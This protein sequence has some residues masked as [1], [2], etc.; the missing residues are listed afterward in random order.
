M[1]FYGLVIVKSVSESYPDRFGPDEYDSE[2]R[3]ERSGAIRV[4]WRF[5]SSLVSTGFAIWSP[6]KRG[7]Y[8]KIS[9]PSKYSI[10]MK[11]LGFW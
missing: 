1:I 8:G 3:L 6:E 11:I 4:K 7:K 10:L 9:K 2:P 5:L